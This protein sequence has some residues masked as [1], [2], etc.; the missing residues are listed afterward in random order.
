MGTESRLQLTRQTLTLQ[1]Q[2]YRYQD[3][4]LIELAPFSHVE[5]VERSYS[6]TIHVHVAVPCFPSVL[7]RKIMTTF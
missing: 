2:Q 5:F 6:E 3:L 4:G 1:L 7:F